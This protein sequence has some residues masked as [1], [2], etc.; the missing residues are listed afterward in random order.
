MLWKGDGKASQPSRWGSFSTHTQRAVCLVRS[1]NALVVADNIVSAR[2][3]MHLIKVTENVL[4][5]NGDRF[6]VPTMCKLD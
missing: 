1:Y 4:R 5:I 2:E 6:E 3:S